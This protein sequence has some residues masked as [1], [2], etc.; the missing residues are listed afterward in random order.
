MKTG[1]K[2]VDDLSQ[3]EFDYFFSRLLV[4]ANLYLYSDYATREEFNSK[5]RK[6][7]GVILD[8]IEEN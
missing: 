1:I 7:L 4:W 5:E 6:I 3:D 2:E 8:E